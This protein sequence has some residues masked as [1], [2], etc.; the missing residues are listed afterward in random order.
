MIILL[1]WLIGFL[2]HLPFAFYAN[3]KRR[4]G[5]RPWVVITV[6][7]VWPVWHIATAWKYIKSKI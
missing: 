2:A 7:A 3:K 4:F 6:A 5:F 1:I